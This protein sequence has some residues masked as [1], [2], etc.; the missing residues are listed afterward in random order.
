MKTCPFCKRETL[1]DYPNNSISECSLCG[2]RQYL[3]KEKEEDDD[4]D[5]DEFGIIEYE[6]EGESEDGECESYEEIPES[7]YE[8]AEELVKNALIS[9]GTLSGRAASDA[10]EI[11][12][13]SNIL[14]PYDICVD[15][16]TYKNARIAYV[17]SDFYGKPDSCK[18]VYHNGRLCSYDKSRCLKII[19]TVEEA[20]L[21]LESFDSYEALDETGYE[22]IENKTYKKL[23]LEEVPLNIRRIGTK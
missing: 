1:Q 15:G 3:P 4:V 20:F 8:Q 14:S 18:R 11:V 22:F 16:I 21:V 12:K 13:N 2:W 19:I 6:G 10:I 7:V 23:A 5:W 17:E 9:L